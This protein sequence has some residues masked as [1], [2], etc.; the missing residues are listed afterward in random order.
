MAYSRSAPKLRVPCGDSLAS[1][2]VLTKP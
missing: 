1:F 2:R